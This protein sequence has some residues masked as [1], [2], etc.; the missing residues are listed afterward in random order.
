MFPEISI[1]FEILLVGMLAMM[2]YY[3]WR[4]N[5]KLSD[6][7]NDKFELEK[8]LTTFATSTERAED[9]ILRLKSKASETVEVLEEKVVNA[10]KLRDELS[11]MVERANEM[12]DRL[13]AAINTG[14][15]SQSKSYGRSQDKSVA[16]ASDDESV[17]D[18]SRKQDDGIDSESKRQ[19]KKSDL[20]KA[21]EGMR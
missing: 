9:S 11:F 13:E 7:R 6:L 2:I 18:L 5:E 20:L 10:V 8:L 3:A 1:L 14:R 19:E 16:A 21:L 15:R 4:L 17:S 12:A